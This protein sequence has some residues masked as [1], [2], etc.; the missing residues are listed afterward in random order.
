LTL[1]FRPTVEEANAKISLKLGDQEVYYTRR[2][3]VRPSLLE[4]IVLPRDRIGEKDGE[5]VLDVE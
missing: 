5:V 3:Y 4:R 1:F 2:P